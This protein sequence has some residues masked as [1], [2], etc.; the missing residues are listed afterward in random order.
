MNIS[1]RKLRRLIADPDLCTL[2]SSNEL[3]LALRKCSPEDS[4]N[5]AAE[6]LRR[7]WLRQDKYDTLLQDLKIMNEEQYRSFCTSFTWRKNTAGAASV[8]KK[9]DIF[10]YATPGNTRLHTKIRDL[11]IETLAMDGIIPL[12]NQREG[13]GRCLFFKLEESTTARVID[14]ED[15][16]HPEW[17]SHVAEIQRN[18]P[19]KYQVRIAG[20][21]EDLTGC[22]LQLPV[23]LAIWRK[24][25]RLPQYN[26]FDLVATGCFNNETLQ[27]VSGLENKGNWL[28]NEIG[29]RVFVHPANG[30]EHTNGIQLVAGLTLDELETEIKEIIVDYALAPIDKDFCIEQIR[31][32]EGKIRDGLVVRW[33]DTLDRLTSYEKILHP[34]VDADAYFQANM[35]ISVALCHCGRAA[36]AQ[37]R[38]EL[39]RKK[40][41]ES[42]K[43]EPYW[44]MMIEA[45]VVNTDLEDWDRAL[46]LSNEIKDN[47][48]KNDDLQMR[49]H[50]SMGQLLAFRC[51]RD[52]KC[53][54]RTAAMEHFSQAIAF[55]QKNG[56]C[57]ELG[58]DL[59]YQHLY[60]ALFTP[61]SAEE[62]EYYRTTANYHH[63]S[64][65]REINLA[66]LA[67]QRNLAAYR[68]LLLNGAKISVDEIRELPD[69]N[70]NDWIKATI[71]KYQG[72]LY[73]AIGQHVQAEECFDHA[74]KMV[75]NAGGSVI[76]GIGMTV[77]AEA[78]RS[79]HRDE[80]AQHIKNYFAGNEIKIF[81][82][83][84]MDEWLAQD[85]AKALLSYQY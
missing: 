12:F 17:S 6:W 49:F 48:M 56:S 3:E 72:A 46:A 16:I 55:A 62:L 73:A 66:F 36:E 60:Y 82:G 1:D 79:L 13:T 24:I 23:L 37:K 53:T 44:R 20:G 21:D 51:L 80:Y 4:L 74:I 52:D 67:R 33:Q 40:A 42:G 30:D 31:I 76:R 27:A 63:Q 38:N 54:G 10:A 61:G 77:A 68:N 81:A 64:E 26:I 78:W 85:N 29:T 71:L 39:M 18:I 58:Q 7:A 34:A 84:P 59:N 5:L 25:D 9:Q 57:R 14:K 83:H 2:I 11:L 28:K 47:I 41:L 75:E 43:N 22:S 45:L 8:L 65:N 70:R 15:N 32:L 19:E 35:L 69:C 50:G